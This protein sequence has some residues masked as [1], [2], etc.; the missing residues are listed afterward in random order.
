V[1]GGGSSAVWSKTPAFYAPG[2]ED[3]PVYNAL[4]VVRR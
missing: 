3:R 1:D 2:T 4:V